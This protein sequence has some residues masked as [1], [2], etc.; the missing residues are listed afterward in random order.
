MADEADVSDVRQEAQTSGRINEI[1]RAAAE[2]PEGEPGECWHCGEWSGR[3]VDGACAPC[4]D[5]FARMAMI[6]GRG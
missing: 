4:R 1:R 6:S 3:L 2:I 5:R